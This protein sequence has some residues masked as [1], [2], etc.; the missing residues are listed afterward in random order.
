MLRFAVRTKSHVGV[1]LYME[2]TNTYIYRT[3]KILRITLISDFS[4]ITLFNHY[5]ILNNSKR[6]NLFMGKFV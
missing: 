5:Y 6:K 1:E 2:V 4:N 3:I